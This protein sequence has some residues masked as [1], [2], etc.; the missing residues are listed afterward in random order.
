MDYVILFTLRIVD[1]I[2]FGPGYV[3]QLKAKASAA[4][5]RFVIVL[6]GLGPHIIGVQMGGSTKH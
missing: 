6:L 2:Y 3:N 1:F 4:S 5:R